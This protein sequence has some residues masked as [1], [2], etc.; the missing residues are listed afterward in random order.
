MFTYRDTTKDFLL[1]RETK[2]KFSSIDRL[3]SCLAIEEPQA[4][5]N[6]RAEVKL[7]V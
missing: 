2:I 1:L 7:T 5:C 4:T 6:T 3:L